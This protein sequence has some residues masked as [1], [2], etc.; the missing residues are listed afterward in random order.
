MALPKRRGSNENLKYSNSPGW[1]GSVSGLSASLQTKG[2][3][4][5]FP[6][7]AHT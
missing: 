6:V 7:Q 5:Q 2:S 3:L 4:V 1:C